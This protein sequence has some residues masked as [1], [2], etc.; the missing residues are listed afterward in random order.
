MSK[1]SEYWKNYV[2]GTWIDGGAGRIDVLNPATGERLAQHAL[3]NE[4]DVD[5]AVA[6]ARRVHLSGGHCQV[7][8][9]RN[10][11]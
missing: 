1:V 6:V 3:A 4:I 10:F 2:D 11:A 7:V 8:F 5:N 9:V